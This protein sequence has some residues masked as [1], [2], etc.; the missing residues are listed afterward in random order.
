MLKAVKGCDVVIHAAANTCQNGLYYK[1]YFAVNVTGTKNLLRAA[2]KYDILKFIFVSTA[3]A[4]RPGTK[5]NPGN[6]EKPASYPFTSSGYTL[7][8]INAQKMVLEYSRNANI[9]AIVVNPSFMIGPYDSRPSSGRIFIMNFGKKIILLPPGGKSFIHVRD[10]TAGI[11]NAIKMGRKGECYL[12]TNENLTFSE[13]YL[14]VKNVTGENNFQLKLFSPILKT[15]GLVGDIGGR[16]GMKTG[17]TSINC[18]ML[19]IGNYFSS[20][21]AVK[22]LQLP[23]TPVELAIADAFQWFSENGYLAIGLFNHKVL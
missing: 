8:K 2:L 23:Q 20:K 12:L 22:E 13:F 5:N 18:K 17:L 11:C 14:K 16:A 7:S 21:K 6:E 3:S 1:D 9:D 4:F 10:A 15:I 19:C